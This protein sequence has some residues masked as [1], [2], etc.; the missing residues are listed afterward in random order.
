MR[1]AAVLLCLLAWVS[2]PAQTKRP[3]LFRAIVY[4]ETGLRTDGILYELTDSTLRYVRDTSEAIAQLWAGQVPEVVEIH[5]RA[6]E[7]IVLRR[8][9]NA[10]RS[11][12]IGGGVGTRFCLWLR[13]GSGGNCNFT[14]PRL[15]DYCFDF[16]KKNETNQSKRYRLRRIQAGTFAIFISL[17]GKE[18]P[19]TPVCQLTP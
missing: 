1:V 3:K 10:G 5:A 6:M 7:K 19:R 8:K 15:G 4:T 2:S 9:G 14:R 11:A 13:A 17:S 12:L 18:S 16:P